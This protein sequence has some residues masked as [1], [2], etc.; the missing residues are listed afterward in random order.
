MG[1][2]TPSGELNA[3]AIDSHVSTVDKGLGGQGC[4]PT[5]ASGPPQGRFYAEIATG[6]RP[7][8]SSTGSHRRS[9]PP[10]ASKG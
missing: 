6:Q 10:L 5:P 1:P 3:M 2:F 8:G 7:S 4:T 9:P